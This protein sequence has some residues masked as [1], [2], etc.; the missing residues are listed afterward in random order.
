MVHL[1]IDDLPFQIERQQQIQ[2]TVDQVR[3]WNE[4]L[5]AQLAAHQVKASAFFNCGRLRPG[6]GMVAAWADAG[7]TIGNHTQSHLPARSTPV[8]DF[9]ADTERCT[10]VLA[11]RGHRPAHFRFPYLSHGADPESRSAIAVGLAKQGLRNAPISAPTSE[12]VFAY[13]YRDALA[14]GD[15]A[16]AE[17]IVAAYLDHMEQAVRAS[18]A[19]GERLHGRAFPQLVLLHANELNAT[20]LGA[21][22]ERLQRAGVRFVDLPTALA[23]PIYAQPIV[24][25]TPYSMAWALRTHPGPFDDWDLYWFRS[26]EETAIEQW[27][28]FMTDGWDGSRWNTGVPPG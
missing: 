4:R 27:G 8:E 5:L 3:T 26:A 20:H 17:Q 15:A 24:R 19:L 18:V 7:H 10:T 12:W 25:E 1:S 16:R 11:E 9:L 22:I 23:D 14:A 13:A 6:D 21:V 2:L 28:S